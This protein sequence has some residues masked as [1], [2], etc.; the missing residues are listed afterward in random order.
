[1]RMMRTSRPSPYLTSP[2]TTSGARITIFTTVAKSF[3][4]PKGIVVFSLQKTWHPDTY[5]QLYA[6]A[7]FVMMIDLILI[8]VGFIVCWLIFP[9][10]RSISDNFHTS[11]IMYFIFRA[12]F[13]VGIPYGVVKFIM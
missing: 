5:S 3:P 13:S 6:K 2:A 11:P 1:M 7:L 12:M 8:A 10:T 9:L 4:P